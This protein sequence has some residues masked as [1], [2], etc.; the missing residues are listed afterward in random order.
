V[1]WTSF[2]RDDGKLV[3]FVEAPLN[4]VADGAHAVVASFAAA[5]TGPQLAGEA[6]WASQR[7]HIELPEPSTMVMVDPRKGKLVFHLVQP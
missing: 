7:I 5:P 1:V 2:G 4:L 6:G 3:T